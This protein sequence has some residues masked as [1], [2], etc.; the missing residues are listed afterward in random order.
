MRRL[1]YV[2]I[3]LVTPISLCEENASQGSPTSSVRESSNSATDYASNAA[4]RK[5]AVN[6]ILERLCKQPEPG[7]LINGTLATSLQLIFCN[8]KDAESASLRLTSDYQAAVLEKT[9]AYEA[10]IAE[11]RAKYD[12][13]MIAQLPPEKQ[14]AAKNLLEVSRA[15]LAKA[16]AREAQLRA[17]VRERLS[18]N[19]VQPAAPAQNVS[20]SSKPVNTSVLESTNSWI[21]LKRREA[22]RQDD[23]TVLGLIQMLDADD[24]KRMNDAYRLRPIT[25]A[26][27]QL[28]QPISNKK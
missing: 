9:R 6:E 18:G 14:A 17:D 24:A 1:C 11:L 19:G 25:P 7:Q 5:K 12:A 8:N 4:D 20:M 13:E 21:R 10:E 23:E 16:V 22:I 27:L 15:K 2:L 26:P 3:I 28:A